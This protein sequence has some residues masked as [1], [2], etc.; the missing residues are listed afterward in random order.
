MTYV[1]VLDL[2]GSCDPLEMS[3]NKPKKRKTEDR[4]TPFL[5][6]DS[7]I[8]LDFL[9]EC[10]ADG[11]A[12]SNSWK[13]TVHRDDDCSST[14]LRRNPVADRFF[15]DD[16]TRLQRGESVTVFG[17]PQS[18]SPSDTEPFSWVQAPNG[19]SGYIKTA[20]L[21]RLAQQGE[22]VTVLRYDGVQQMLLRKQPSNEEDWVDGDLLA[23]GDRLTLLHFH[24]EG[25]FAWVRTL[26]GLEGYLRAK[27][28]I[29]S[30]SKYAT[31]ASLSKLGMQKKVVEKAFERMYKPVRSWALDRYGQRPTR[32][33][34]EALGLKDEVDALATACEKLTLGMLG[35][36]TVLAEIDRCFL[37]CPNPC[38]SNTPTR[39]PIRSVGSFASIVP[40]TQSEDTST[41][42][43]EG[44]QETN[45]QAS[46]S[47]EAEANLSMEVELDIDCSQDESSE[48]VAVMNAESQT[49]AQSSEQGQLN[50]DPLECVSIS[51][52][53]EIEIG[54]LGDLSA[55][56]DRTATNARHPASH[57]SSRSAGGSS[58]L[59]RCSSESLVSSLEKMNAIR[60]STLSNAT[61]E[62][63]TN[64][65]ESGS[66]GPYGPYNPPPCS[67]PEPTEPDPL[68]GRLIVMTRGKYKGTLGRVQRKV[69]K[70]YRVQLDGL[71]YGLEYYAQAFDVVD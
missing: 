66:I 15:V 43:A 61:H 51:R 68:Q 5:R 4:A 70:K 52:Q 60:N 69:K 7:N 50:P 67:A 40:T 32:R 47:M 48:N 13:A 1:D 19:V 30:E 3:R 14:Q 46:W 28:I 62:E 31:Q 56:L 59:E 21:V 18:E 39:P 24:S 35:D 54:D 58:I 23:I 20:Y 37:S 25:E 34:I 33:L 8:S 2:R 64:I 16:C 6:I 53:I 17:E 44:S 22:E 36:Q 9:M 38:D 12:E 11:M 29:P 26:S 42:M 41:F 57:A 55:L 10:N 27:Y 63:C 49:S 71:E 65:P 45:K